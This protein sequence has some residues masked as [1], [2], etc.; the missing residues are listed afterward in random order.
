MRKGKSDKTVV[1]FEGGGACC[2]DRTSSFPYGTRVPQQ[3]YVPSIP[4]GTTP[5]NYNG[6]FRSDRADNPVRDWNFVYIP[7]CTGDIH[8][9]SATKDYSSIGGPVPAGTPITIQH[10]GFDNFMAVLGW[11]KHN[12]GKPKQILVTGSSAGGYGAT[13]NFAWIEDNFKTAHVS[14]LADASQGVTTPAFDVSDPGRNS[15]N[16]Q[17]APGVYGV[18]PS[19]VPGPEFMR[20][21]ALAYPRSKVAQFTTTVDTVQIEFYGAM[22]LFYG[23]G[24]SCP[25]PAVDWN[26]QMLAALQS[27]AAE[28]PNFRHYL[29]PGTYHTIMR[30]PHFYTEA[31]DGVPFAGWVGNMLKNRGG[32]GG[33]GG[34]WH[35]VACPECLIALPCQ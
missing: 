10:R 6:I 5:A 20:R 3:Y 34:G 13:V 15:W 27:D 35:N 14:L 32:T 11:M 25:N 1:F 12:L 23:P 21:T 18:D 28:V 17:L 24:G 30:S 29:A 22:K 26:Q 31:V 19:L 16:P 33:S 9:G 8:T 4:P 2:D 7:Y